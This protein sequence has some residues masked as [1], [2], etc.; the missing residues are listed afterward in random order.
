MGDNKHVEID[1]LVP[2]LDYHSIT[3]WQLANSMPDPSG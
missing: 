1:S 2:G 3:G